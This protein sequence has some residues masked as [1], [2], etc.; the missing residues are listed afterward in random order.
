MIP[1]IWE[2][3]LEL[4]PWLLLG[5]A[6]AGVLHG[7]LP[8]D[9]I[10]QQLTGR[11]AVFK[12]VAFGIPL[13]LCS[14]GVIPA[15]LGLKKDG[16]SDAASVG[17]LISTPQTGL[18]SIFVAAG[19][20][21][22][23]F[24]LFKVLSALIMGLA[25]GSLTTRWGGARIELDD[26]VAAAHATDTVVHP[27]WDIVLHA[28]DLLHAIWRWLIFGVVASALITV[29][30]PAEFFAQ[31]PATMEW[32]AVLL[33]AIPLYVCATSSVPIAAALVAAGMPLGAALIFLMAGP[34]TNMATLG[35]VYR[36]FG[37]RI[38]AIY[39]ATIVVGSVGLAWLFNALLPSQKILDTSTHHHEPALWALLGAYVLMALM[40][41][42]AWR[43]VRVLFDRWFGW[44]SS[45]APAFELGIEGMT[46]GGCVSK[47][48]AELKQVAGVSLAVVTLEPA[49]AK[50]YGS[51]T[52]ES[53][54]QA[55][56]AAGFTAA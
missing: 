52:E 21:G 35:A 53:V 45:E 18:D 30:L 40:V 42:C 43:D 38:L 9:F 50:V 26:G 1:A 13:P 32:L 37:K 28:F 41:L 5:L 48:Q 15:G 6:I 16:A 22:W 44:F 51:P 36:G 14:C 23:P 19:F 55:V 20:L 39:L 24:A 29:F 8:K 3:W 12:A 2:V 7:L 10:R 4:A 56:E 27:L 17:F 54:R 34:A 11:Y 46:C 47:L 33:F 25:G 31:M 49:Q